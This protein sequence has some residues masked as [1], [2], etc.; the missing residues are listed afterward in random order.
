LVVGYSYGYF[1]HTDLI[2]IGIVL[3]IVEFFGLALSVAFYWPLLGI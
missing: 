2:K 1:K 3:T